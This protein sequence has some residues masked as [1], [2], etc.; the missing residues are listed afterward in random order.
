MKKYFFTPI[1]FLPLI[2]ILIC[3]D[4]I[5]IDMLTEKGNIYYQKDDYENAIIIYEDLLAEQ[6]LQYGYDSKQLAQTM[7]LLG[8][9]YF[10]INLYF[11]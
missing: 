4:E 7:T 6:E 2:S 3:Q 8:E 9:L 11:L 5:Q 10:L 1:F